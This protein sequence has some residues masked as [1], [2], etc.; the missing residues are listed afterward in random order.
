VSVIAKG[1][2]SGRSGARGHRGTKFR[3]RM[4]AIPEQKPEHKKTRTLPPGFLGTACA[5]QV[6]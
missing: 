2:Q 3:A 6:E 5:V 1:T 4:A